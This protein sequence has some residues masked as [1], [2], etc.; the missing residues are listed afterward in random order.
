MK[1]ENEVIEIFSN[2]KRKETEFLVF[3]YL[4]LK[5]YDFNF[6]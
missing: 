5:I 1:I 6:D 2:S 3:L 4:N